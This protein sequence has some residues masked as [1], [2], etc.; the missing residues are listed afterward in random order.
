[1]YRLHAAIALLLLA[2]TLAFTL[3][4]AA[5]A[6]VNPTITTIAPATGTTAGGTPVTITGT[7][8]LPG[9]TVYIGS[10]PASSVVV[11]SPT[12]ITAVT[13]ARTQGSANLLVVNTDGGVGSAAAVYFFTSPT[14]P[15]SITGVTP[16]TGPTAGATLITVTGTGFAIGATVL[17]DNIPA[18]LVTWLGSS[19]LWA[20]APPNSAGSVTLSVINPDGGSATLADAFTYSGATGVTVTRVSPTG[21][22]VT[23]G[24][25][26]TVTG[27]GF[28]SGATVRFGVTNATNVVFLNSTQLIATTPAAAAGTVSVTVTNPNG[29]NQTIPNSF[30][31]GVIGAGGPTI[32][33]ASPNTGSTAGGTTI[34]IIGTGF[35]GGSTVLFGGAAS[36]SVTFHAGGSQMFV[37]T[38]ANNPGPATITI[39]NSSGGASTLPG[40]FTYEGASGLTVTN[41]TPSAG[42]PAG[43]ATVTINGSGFASGAMVLFGTVPAATATLMG[44]TQIVA[45]TPAAPA[46]TVNVTVTNTGGLSA[47]LPNGY[48]FGTEIGG[49]QGP[50]T[51]TSVTPNSGPPAGGSV[52]TIKGSGFVVGASVLFGLVPGTGVTVVNNAQITVTAPS[53]SVSS[54]ALSVT[55]VNPGGVSGSISAAF[56][57]SA[58]AGPLAVTTITPTSGALAGGTSVTISGSG[59]SAV[60]SVLFGGAPG[61]ALTVTNDSMLTVTSPPRAAG[62]VTVTVVTAS[63]SSATVPSGFLYSAS[64]SNTEF[65]SLNPTTG[66]TAGGTTVTLTG[67]GFAAGMTVTFGGA[68]AAAVNVA[69]PTQATAVVPARTAGTVDVV[70]NVAGQSATLASGFTYQVGAAPGPINLPARGFGLFVFAGGTSEQLLTA[71]GCPQASAAYYATNPAGEFVVYVPGTSIGAVNAAWRALFPASIP[72]NTPLV[73]RC[74]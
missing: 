25:N 29:A 7:G 9:A 28:A 10:S 60:T 36:P 18:T 54:G 31:F 58:N 57:Y 44:S 56:T 43:G 73:G 61:T 16:S 23:G 68:A 35:T 30:T 24:A 32:T 42:P 53:N 48:T 66:S 22:L 70:L 51:V 13:P 17:M 8:F 15:L 19:Q 47:V 65:T 33:N 64:A 62:P 38:P 55:V 71:T 46:G 20:H 52:V 45:T 39:I 6:A 4:L 74:S 26:V 21:G 2:C 72:A 40:G 3:P 50:L 12:Q 14:A 67:S 5:A 11:V 63:G 59:L 27:T 1:M 69:S 37:V 41:I 34:T 49:Q